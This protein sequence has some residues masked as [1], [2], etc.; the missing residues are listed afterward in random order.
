MGSM[1]GIVSD[2]SRVEPDNLYFANWKRL[3][4]VSWKIAYQAGRNFNMPP[5]SVGDSAVCYYFEPRS[6]GRG[7]TCSFVIM[8]AAAAGAGF[9]TAPAAAAPAAA[10][11]KPAVGPELVKILNDSAAGSREQDLEI[12]RRLIE[13]IDGYIG[14]GLVTPDELSAMEQLLQQVMERNGIR[15]APASR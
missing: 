4:D 14:S 6:L 9:N 8:L 12:I 7:E 5:Y 2:A 13:E 11:A 1:F 15:D 3:N 10:A